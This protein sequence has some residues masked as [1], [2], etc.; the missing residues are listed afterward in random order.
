M[1]W[2]H[3]QQLVISCTHFE[4]VLPTFGY[5]FIGASFEK[6]LKVSSEN[7]N[8]LIEYFAEHLSGHA[9]NYLPS[10]SLNK[11]LINKR[12]FQRIGERI[13]EINTRFDVHVSSTVSMNKTYTQFNIAWLSGDYLLVKEY[14]LQLWRKLGVFVVT[15]VLS[16][17]RFIAFSIR[18]LK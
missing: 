3:K 1:K 15:A 6:F 10:G 2:K 13:D 4:H 18:M 16:A 7:S 17:E 14:K 8:A 5:I 11:L 9:Y 12:V